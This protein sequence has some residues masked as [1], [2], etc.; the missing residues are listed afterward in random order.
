MTTHISSGAV[1]Y[2]VGGGGRREVLLLYRK[3]TNSWHLPKGT[4]HDGETLEHTAMR[5]V[6]EETGFAV[7]L[8]KYLGKLDSVI[9]RENAVI[10]KET[11]YFI[12]QVSGGDAARHDEEHDEVVFAEFGTALRRLEGFSLHEKEGEILKM[13]ERCFAM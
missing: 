5:E 3:D 2:R 7:K 4:Q 9:H 1:A 10:P 11:H 12:A 13:A 6:E 8:E